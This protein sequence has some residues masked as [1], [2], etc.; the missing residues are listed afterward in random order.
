M[1]KGLF[2]LLIGVL[3][4]A[5][6]LVVKMPAAVAYGFI[7][8]ELQPLAVS[9]VEGTIWSG[10]ASQVL[11][12]RRPLGAVRWDL[13][14]L[15]LVVGS[16]S[17]DV[18]LTA[19]A[20][21]V[22]TILTRSMDGSLLLENVRGRLEVSPLAPWVQLQAFRPEGKLSLD[23]ERVGLQGKR[24]TEAVGEIVWS[25][26]RIQSPR[27]LPLGG[28]IATFSTTPQGVRAVLRDRESPFSLDA[29][30]SLQSNGSYQ[31]TGQIAASANADPEIHQLMQTLG[32]RTQGGAIPINFAGRL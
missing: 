19:T 11:Y 1:K 2:Y 6:F 26:A 31:L 8:Q 22:E 5:G 13:N 27:D 21:S 12:Q 18:S 15:P 25:E 28:L 16:V 4:Y 7:A 24:P 20:G 30:V 29:T 14:P 32:V 3:A 17:A 23:L 9:G 10:R